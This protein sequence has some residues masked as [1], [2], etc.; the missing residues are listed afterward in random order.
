METK[1]KW[2]KLINYLKSTTYNVFLLLL[3][4]TCI[5]DLEK[6]VKE[7]TETSKFYVNF[8]F[9]IFFFFSLQSGAFEICMINDVYLKKI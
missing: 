5:P 6:H 8:I 7:M 1:T 4:C 3:E 2:P 9:N